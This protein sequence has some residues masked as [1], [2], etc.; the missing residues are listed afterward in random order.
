MY[1]LTEF[2]HPSYKESSVQRPQIWVLLQIYCTLYT[3][4]PRGMTDAAVTRH[5]SFA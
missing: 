5:M 4:C 3:D 1:I 2:R